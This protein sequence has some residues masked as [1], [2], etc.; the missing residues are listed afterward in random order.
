MSRY[1]V[2]PVIIFLLLFLGMKSCDF[3][4][5][6]VCVV[7]IMDVLVPHP[8]CYYFQERRVVIFLSFLFVLSFVPLF[9]VNP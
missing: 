3:P 8:S 7:L 2:I 6:L 4:F 1:L 9:L 5:L